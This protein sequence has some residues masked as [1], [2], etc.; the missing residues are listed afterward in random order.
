MKARGGMVVLILLALAPLASADVP[1][2]VSL[3]GRLTDAGGSPVAGP[4]TL[5]FAVYNNSTAGAA[6]W[7]ETQ[8]GVVLSNGVF[9]VLLGSVTPLN[10][11]FNESYWVAMTVNGEVQNPRLRLAAAP[12]AVAANR[13]QNATYADRAAVADNLSCAGCV[14]GTHLAP[15]SATTLA[16]GWDVCAPGVNASFVL[17]TPAQGFAEVR[18][19]L[20]GERALAYE[21]ADAY[22][23]ATGVGNV[24]WTTAAGGVSN[25][26]TVTTSQVDATVFTSGPASAGGGSAT[27]THT[28]TVNQ[29]FEHNHSI[30]SQTTALNRTNASVNRTG[31]LPTDAALF[32]DGTN[33]TGD[34]TWTTRSPAQPRDLMLNQTITAW[35]SAAGVHWLDVACTAPG[36]VRFVIS[37]R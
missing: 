11:S 23:K 34:V 3:S 25:A 35:T 36:A 12:Y 13:S 33:R 16:Q 21:R 37:A 15:G 20:F 17:V 19:Y 27:G 18:L 24:S 4:A 32:V 31:A 8:N 6:L 26:G 1:S 22:D 29:L 7:A 9:S 14:N 30:T 28:H 2:L 10:L 5:A